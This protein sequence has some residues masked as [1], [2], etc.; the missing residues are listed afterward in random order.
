MSRRS[1][2][3]K[4][5]KASRKNVFVMLSTLLFVGVVTDVSAITPQEVMENALKVYEDIDNYKAIVQT[6]EADSM[7]A[8]GRIFQVQQP[9]I[10]F[11]LFFRKPGEHVVGQISKSRHGIFRVEVLSALRRLSEIELKLEAREVLLGQNCYVLACTSPDEPDTLI[12]LWISPTDWTVQQFTLIMKSLTL[13]NTQFKYPP[14]G[15]RR[16]RFLPVETRSFFPLSKKVLI[17]RITDYRV[18][19]RLPSAVFEENNEQP[20]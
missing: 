8:S 13:A 12:K 6:Y 3:S 10:S 18:N 16:V 7:E 20:R 15:K 1:I 19:T 11:N 14:G 5:Q 17:N 4:A 2:L 9:I